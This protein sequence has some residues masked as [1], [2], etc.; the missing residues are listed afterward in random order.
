MST[1]PRPA[2]DAQ[3]YRTTAT[4]VRA[5]AQDTTTTPALREQLLTL[6]AQFDRLAECAE[7]RTPNAD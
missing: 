5:M 1:A 3:R 4:E 7:A 2:A 6:T